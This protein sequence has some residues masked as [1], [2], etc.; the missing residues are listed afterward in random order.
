MEP[1]RTVHAAW[2]CNGTLSLDG[3]VFTTQELQQ[4]AVDHAALTSCCVH[5]E[6]WLSA[7]TMQQHRCMREV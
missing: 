4:Y 1:L 5:V 6:V 2:S 3:C 7:L